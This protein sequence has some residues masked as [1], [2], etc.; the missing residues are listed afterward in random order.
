MVLMLAHHWLFAASNGV[1]CKNSSYN[2]NPHYNLHWRLS[3]NV[4]QRK[5]L[6]DVN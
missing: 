4:P 6:S 1:M 5:H 3:Y 2:K